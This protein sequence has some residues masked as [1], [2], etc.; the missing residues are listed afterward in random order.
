MRSRR[1]SAAGLRVMKQLANPRT[2]LQSA[3][4]ILPVPV[5]ERIDAACVANGESE[6]RWRQ[7][8]YEADE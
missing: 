4:S 2:R 1:L 3:V 7:D 5:I 8:G 6:K